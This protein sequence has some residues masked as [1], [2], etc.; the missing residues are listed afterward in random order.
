ML[1][2]K[3]G[4][5][6]LLF[7]SVVAVGFAGCGLVQSDNRT[8]AEKRDSADKTRDEVAKAT[9][10][11]KPE[12]EKA[13]RELKEAA[14]AAAEQAHAA[15]QG[16]REGWERGGHRS[17]DINSASESDLM[18]LPGITKREARRIIASRP[19]NRAADLVD[20]GVLSEERYTQIRDRVSAH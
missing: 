11:A 5:S 15:A 7:A 13:G 12:L 16:V 8:E 9:E 18:L 17:V 1:L 6:I 14:K 19:Y 2:R 3:R 4:V 10:R 20:R